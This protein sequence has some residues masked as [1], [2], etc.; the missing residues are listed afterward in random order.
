MIQLMAVMRLK[1]IRMQAIRIQFLFRLTLSKMRQKP[2]HVKYLH[3]RYFLQLFSPLQPL[4]ATTSSAESSATVCYC[5]NL[6]ARKICICRKN[7]LKC[8]ERCHPGKPQCV[9]KDVDPDDIIVLNSDSA[10]DDSHA[11]IWSSTCE[12]VVTS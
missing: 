2:R 3:L 7:G 9:N 8:T 6:C 5:R 10:S 11:T 4:R 12:T 1:A